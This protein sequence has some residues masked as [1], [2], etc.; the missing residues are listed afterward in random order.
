MVNAVVVVLVCCRQARLQ[1][2]GHGA[3]ALV[4]RDLLTRQ[5]DVFLD[6]SIG[7]RS[8]RS[9][10]NFTRVLEN[11]GHLSQ[12]QYSSHCNQGIHLLCKLCFGGS[13][14]GR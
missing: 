8:N 13:F 11:E 9:S 1:G 7:L 6:R 4:G 12:D 2:S 10:S 3:L 14:Q 5:Q